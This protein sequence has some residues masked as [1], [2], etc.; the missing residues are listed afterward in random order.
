MNATIRKGTKRDSEAFLDLLVRLAAFEHLEPPSKAAKMRI[1]AD[2][3]EKKRVSLFVAIVDGKHVGYALYFYTYSSFLARPTLYV[4][5]I[6]VVEA[7]R[8]K[9]IG[10]ALFQACAKEAAKQ[11]CGRMEW[12][13]LT[14]NSNA[15]RFYERLGARRLDEW[16]VYR[17]PSEA[18]ANPSHTRR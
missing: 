10:F 16:Y 7:F 5:D 11:R 2:V 12:A 1:V 13:V 9:G 3:F 18:F 4:E 15:I 6:F 8:G 14:W 17:L